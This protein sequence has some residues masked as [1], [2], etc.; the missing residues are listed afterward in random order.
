MDTI[1]GTV[2]QFMRSLKRIDPDLRKQLMRRVKALGKPV[3]TAIKSNLPAISVLI[4]MNNKGR[5]G[6]GIGKPANSTT[7]RFKST[8]SKMSSV[9][10]LL[11]VVVNSPAMVITDMAGRRSEGKTKSGRQ[12]IARL[13]RERRASRFVYP[14]GDKAKPGVDEQIKVTI[15][16][17]ARETLRNL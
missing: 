13:N 17:A 2:N 7:L 3:E 10:P 5:L 11:S 4:G 15:E 12:M 1:E 9:S 14:A 6:W 16:E 8:A